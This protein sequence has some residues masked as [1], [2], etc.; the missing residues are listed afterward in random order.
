MQRA[1]IRRL[2]DQVHTLL[3]RA[4]PVPSPDED[5]VLLQRPFSSQDTWTGDAAVEGDVPRATSAFQ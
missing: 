1:E 5:H 2:R 4:Q 3:A